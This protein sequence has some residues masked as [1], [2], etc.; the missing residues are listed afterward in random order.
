MGMDFNLPH[1]G[2]KYI[3]LLY[4]LSKLISDSKI[5]SRW[6]REMQLHSGWKIASSAQGSPKTGVLPCSTWEP[7]ASVMVAFV[8]LTA[9]SLSFPQ[10]R[11]TLRPRQCWTPEK[12]VSL[13]DQGPGIWSPNIPVLGTWA[14]AECQSSFYVPFRK[15]FSASD[16]LFFPPEPGSCI[17]SHF[18]ALPVFVLKTLSNRTSLPGS[19]RSWTK[20]SVTFSK[21]K[22]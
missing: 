18:Q 17:C 11:A 10:T 12:F 13:G 20:V 21:R 2:A 8:L 1:S 3:T 7:L 9:S 6:W 4:F 15:T 16:S 5:L 14:E 19:Y 22:G